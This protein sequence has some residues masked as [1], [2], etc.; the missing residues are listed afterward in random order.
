MTMELINIIFGFGIVSKKLGSWGFIIYL[1]LNA[2]M[3][4]MGLLG[5][6]IEEKARALEIEDKNLASQYAH[7][8]E[9]WVK[10]PFPDF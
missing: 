8:C 10:K 6:K 5:K 3:I 7:V 1:L 4:I 9:S 2:L